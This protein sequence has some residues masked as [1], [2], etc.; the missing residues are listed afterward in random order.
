MNDL[1]SSFKN[2]Y[3]PEIDG[4]PWTLYYLTRIDFGRPTGRL[5]ALPIA[6]ITLCTLEKV[7]WYGKEISNTG[8][9][10]PRLL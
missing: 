2:V 3:S 1:R 7:P 9:S 8:A 10:I 5:Q 6:S 4:T